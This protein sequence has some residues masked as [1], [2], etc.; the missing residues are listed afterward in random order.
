MI[1]FMPGLALAIGHQQAESSDALFLKTTRS[2]SAGQYPEALAAAN[3]LCQREPKNLRYQLLRGDVSFAAG[4]MD[5][6]VAA[7]DAAI[8]I[9]PDIE[10][11]L[12]QRGLALY[13]ADRFAD[14]VRQF[15]THQTVN[16][17]DVENAVWHLLC[18]A[19]ESDIKRARRKLIPISRDPRVPMPEIYEMF[20]GRLTPDDVIKAARHNTRLVPKNGQRYRLQLYYAYLYIGLYQE[21]LGQLDESLKSIKQAEKLNPLAKTNFMGQVARVHLQLRGTSDQRK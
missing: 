7:F 8:R 11:K 13:Y 9:Q 16:S 15:E 5:Q 6:C 21:M 3:R 19:R 1:R 10:P 18:E 12:W 4:K 17:Q 20:A 14:G 2:F